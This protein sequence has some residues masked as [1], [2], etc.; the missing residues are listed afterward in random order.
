MSADKKLSEDENLKTIQYTC[1]KCGWIYSSRNDACPMCAAPMQL[2][3]K[4][5]IRAFI[6]FAELRGT[7]IAGEDA[8]EFLKAFKKNNKRYPNLT[9]LW[10]AATQLAKLDSMTEEQMKKMEK[11]RKQKGEL[12][13]QMEKMKSQKEVELA[14]AKRK[15]LEELK[16]KED[17]D[18]RKAAQD[19]LMKAEEK[20]KEAKCPSCGAPN[21]GDSKF[22]MECGSKL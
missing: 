7:A 13:A 21:P 20:K 22:C 8:M 17:A 10:G 6:K 2:S 18:R 11:E 12:K 14:E 19:A 5:L 15:H 4:D 3:E 16:M 1:K 9:D